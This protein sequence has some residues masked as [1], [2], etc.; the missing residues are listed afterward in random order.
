MDFKGKP[1]YRSIFCVDLRSGFDGENRGTDQLD[2]YKGTD[3][4]KPGK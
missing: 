4:E 3:Q 1:R 2:R